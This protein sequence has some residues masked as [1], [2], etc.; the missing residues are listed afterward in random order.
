MSVEHRKWMLS[1]THRSK[2]QGTVDAS[3]G[4]HIEV[5]DQYWKNVLSH[6]VALVKF[7]RDRGFL[8]W[9]IMNFWDRH[10]RLLPGNP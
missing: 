6:V 7:L 9:G 3:L 1:L 10:T 8:S 2:L 5:E 4:R